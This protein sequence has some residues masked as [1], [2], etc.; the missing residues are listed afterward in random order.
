MIQMLYPYV[1]YVG[2]PLLL[3]C[4]WLYWVYHKTPLY[5]FSSLAPLQRFTPPPRWR[6]LVLFLTRVGTLVA[7]CCALARFQTPDERSKIPVQGVDIMLVLDASQSM[8]IF[9]DPQDR[10]TRWDVARDEAL[11][12]IDKRENDP[13]GLVLFAGVALSRCP[14][15]LDK[16]ILKEIL[17]ETTTATIAVPGTVLSRAIL[18]AANRLKKST[19]KNKIMIVLT[20]GEPTGNDT[21]PEL[22]IDL[23]KKLGIKIYTVGIGSERG[24][25]IEDPM[26]GL[27]RAQSALNVPLLEKFAHETGGQFFHARNPADMVAIYDTIDTLER[28]EYET[29]IYAR[30]KEHFMFFLWLALMLL[31]IYI[32]LVSLVWVRL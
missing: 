4:S 11:R 27:V 29:P 16:G 14:L 23:A 3:V 5:L 8:I 32:V 6:T 20:D 15:T 24:G 28:T 18:T 22:S 21:R 31:L 2:L 10:R 25:W 9:D 12:F 17:H 26:Y 13:I 19:A 30:Y 7:L 1:I